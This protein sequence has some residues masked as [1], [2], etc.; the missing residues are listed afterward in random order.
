MTHL[1]E[2]IECA[3]HAFGELAE[4]EERAFTLLDDVT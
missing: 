3:S 4:L 2:A 1:P